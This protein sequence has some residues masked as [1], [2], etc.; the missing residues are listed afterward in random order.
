M[1]LHLLFSL[2]HLA[3]EEPAKKMVATVGAPGSTVRL[4]TKTTLDSL[5]DEALKTPK[6]TKHNAS[7]TPA[8][9]ST[10]T[11]Q[12]TPRTFL[13]RIS[14]L[15]TSSSTV[16]ICS[17]VCFYQLVYVSPWPILSQPRLSRSF[18]AV[19]DTWLNFLVQFAPCLLDVLGFKHVLRMER[20]LQFRPLEGSDVILF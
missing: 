13:D 3:L 7:P 9:T 8:T 1:I 17:D 6:A 18:S 20:E 14:F 11:G 19:S 16:L 10:S 15:P 2:P 4:R 5:D 12:A